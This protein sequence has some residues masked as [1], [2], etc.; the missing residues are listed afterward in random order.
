M[1]REARAAIAGTVVA[2]I[3][4]VVVFAF[5]PPFLL[6]LVLSFA[7]GALGARAG[8]AARRNR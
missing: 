2:V 6:V 8:I 3:V 7:C 4:E 5:R 1:N